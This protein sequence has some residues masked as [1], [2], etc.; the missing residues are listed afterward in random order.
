M[1]LNF[2]EDNSLHGLS[3]LYANVTIILQMRA[4]FLSRLNKE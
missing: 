4:V 3:P 2:N 1:T